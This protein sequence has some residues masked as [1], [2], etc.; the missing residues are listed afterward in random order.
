EGV[1]PIEI[2]KHL[3]PKPLL[4]ERESLTL[5]EALKRNPLEVYHLRID[6]GTF[7]SFPEKV[8]S[9]KNLESLWFGGQANLNFETLPDA[10]YQ[11]TRLHTVQIY[12][13]YKHYTLKALSPKISQLTHL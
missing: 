11:L 3:D 2:V 13:G 1:V 12:G 10:F 4:P 8:L 6:K 9:F 5:E 7:D